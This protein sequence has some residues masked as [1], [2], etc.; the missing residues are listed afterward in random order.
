MRIGGPAA[1]CGIYFLMDK[2][3]EGP[4]WIYENHLAAGALSRSCAERKGA[5][6]LPI[7]KTLPCAQD[8]S[9]PHL[10]YLNFGELPG[11]GYMTAN[12]WV[13][14]RDSTYY[15]LVRILSE[16]YLHRTHCCAWLLYCQWLLFSDMHLRVQALETQC[17]NEKV[18][19]WILPAMY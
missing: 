12:F 2:C 10:R 15:I 17:S 5:V 18:S 16:V 19:H 7:S 13:T 9:R 14:C 8:N 1:N 3:Q 6:S 4:S 11:T